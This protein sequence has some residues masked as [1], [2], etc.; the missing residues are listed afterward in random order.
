MLEKKLKGN[1]LKRWVA[2]R[3][4]QTKMTNFDPFLYI[5]VLNA[6]TECWLV[7]FVF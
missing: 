3:V 2:V 7:L 6:L 1:S 5:F 4:V